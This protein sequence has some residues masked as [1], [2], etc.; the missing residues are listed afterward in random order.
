M[1]SLGVSCILTICLVN[2]LSTNVQIGVVSQ[3]LDVHLARLWFDSRGELWLAGAVR[4]ELF[5]SDQ[6]RPTEL[7]RVVVLA[8]NDMNPFDEFGFSSIAEELLQT[9]RPQFLE[10]PPIESSLAN[11]ESLSFALSLRDILR[12]DKIKA[13]SPDEFAALR[14]KLVLDCELRVSWPTLNADP[15]GNPISDTQLIPLPRLRVKFHSRFPS[16]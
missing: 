16:D 2:D 8:N 5:A 15:F 3:S 10:F 6:E 11:G 14:D 12:V 7:S 1:L 13:M 4:Y 9:N